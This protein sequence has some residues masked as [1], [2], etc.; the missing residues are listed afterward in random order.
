MLNKNLN[1]NSL[2]GRGTTKA[3]AK[4]TLVIDNIDNLSEVMKAGEAAS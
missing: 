1:V 3:Y 2:I 4:D